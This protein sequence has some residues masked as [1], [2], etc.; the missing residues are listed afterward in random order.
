MIPFFKNKIDSVMD[1][2]RLERVQPFASTSSAS[3]TR[4][5][6]PT[7]PLESSSNVLSPNQRKTLTLRQARQAHEE[8]ITRQAAESTFTPRTP[9]VTFTQTRLNHT[10]MQPVTIQRIE[11]IDVEI[12]RLR[13]TFNDVTGNSFTQL[14][15]NPVPVAPIS[16][17][18]IP[19]M[20]FASEVIDHQKLINSSE[21]GEL[22]IA[23]ALEPFSPTSIK[24]KGSKHAKLQFVFTLIQKISRLSRVST[25]SRAREM[26]KHTNNIR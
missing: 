20:A 2:I 23:K 26:I 13:E 1:Y 12:N 5:S 10:P 25:C 22:T 18:V 9:T 19:V 6:S 7:P 14:C 3:S 8:R 21:V 15:T 4:T 16:D 11:P 17:E 24:P